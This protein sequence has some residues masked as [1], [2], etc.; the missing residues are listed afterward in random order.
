MQTN[1][2]NKKKKGR[3][4]ILKNVLPTVWSPLEKGREK[5]EQIHGH[6]DKKK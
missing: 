4:E 6:T 5:K 2:T 3:A 1:E